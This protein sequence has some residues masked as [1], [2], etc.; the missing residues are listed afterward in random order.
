MRETRLQRKI[1]KHLIN[2]IEEEALTN[3]EDNS[4]NN[5]LKTILLS[6]RFINLLGKLFIIG[7]LYFSFRIFIA[8]LWLVTVW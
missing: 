1:R 7:G 5:P 4:V 6:F 3:I 2:E 8:M